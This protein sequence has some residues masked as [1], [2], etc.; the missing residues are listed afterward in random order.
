MLNSSNTNW[1]QEVELL[2]LCKHTYVIMIKK[3]GQE[4]KGEDSGGELERL[5]GGDE[6]KKLV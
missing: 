4:F 1:T 5:A 6:Q 3:M 2:Y